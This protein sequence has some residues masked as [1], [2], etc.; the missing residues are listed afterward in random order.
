MASVYVGY[1]VTD[2]GLRVFPKACRLKKAE[3]ALVYAPGDD[4]ISVHI[5]A[6]QPFDSHIVAR[7]LE[8][9]K[10]FFEKLYPEKRFRGYMCISWLLSP[11]LS[12]ILKPSSNILAFG[13]LYERFPVISE[14]L[15]I[16][17]FVFHKTVTTVT[18]DVIASLPESNS[19]ER[20]LKRL[21]KSGGYLHELGGIIPF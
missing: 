6:D 9:G 10:A 4:L 5:P 3:W 11:E 14:G 12:D 18:E 7:S 16:F 21:Y 19:L 17:R 15:D 13:N 2:N 8:T 20:G 1:P